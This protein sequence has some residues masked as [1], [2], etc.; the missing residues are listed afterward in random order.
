MDTRPV[1]LRYHFLYQGPHEVNCLS[2]LITHYGCS[3]LLTPGF[4][5]EL[6]SRNV[7]PTLIKS[8]Y[9]NASFAKLSVLHGAI[10]GGNFERHEKKKKDVMKQSKDKYVLT[11][12]QTCYN[13]FLYLVPY[14]GVSSNQVNRKN[15]VTRIVWRMQLKYMAYCS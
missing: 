9:T 4:V 5:I 10:L 15:F 14:R 1:H 7:E 11:T 8:S 2:W 3:D 13:Y 12:Q 6:T